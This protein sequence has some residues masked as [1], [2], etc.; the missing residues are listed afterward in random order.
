MQYLLAMCGIDWAILTKLNVERESKVSTL[1][2]NFTVVALETWAVVYQNRQNMHF[3]YKSAH[4]GPL[5]QLFFT[6]NLAWGGYPRSAPWRRIS[7]FYL[8]KCDL[9]A[10]KIAK[11]CN[12]RQA[13]A[14]RNH[15]GIVFTQWT[16]NGFF[17]PQGRHIT[18]INVKFGVAPCQISR[19]WGR[20]VGIHP[21]SY[22]NFE[23]WP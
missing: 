13:C 9:T 6:K 7:L 11:N 2:Q 10:R 21:Q 15:A 8:E 3:S 20:N 23:C 4:K 16:I 19:F 22:Q 5:E 12:Y 18:P 17:A 1:A 14:Q